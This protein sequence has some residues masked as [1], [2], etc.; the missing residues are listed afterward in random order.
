MPD[1]V[2]ERRG[3][4]TWLRLN[5]PERRNAYDVPLLAELTAAV[6]DAEAD[7]NVIVITGSGSAFCAGGFLGNLADPDPTEIRRMF[8]G[9]L[10][11]FD[12]IRTSLRPVIASVNGAAAG[13]G[14]E[15]VVACDLA[16]AAES[17]TFGQTGVRVGSAPV[18]GGTNLLAVSIGEKRAKEVAFLCQR[19]SARE[20]LDLGW[21]NRV[22]PDADLE[23]ATD[24]MVADL[25]A[26]SPRY[27]AVAKASSNV[28][29]NACRDSFLSGLAMLDQAIGSEDMLE[30]ARAF[31]EKRPPRFAQPG[32]GR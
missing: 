18:L 30:G 7:S 6:R 9:S 21:I 19:Y 22:V 29:W 25:S 27:L 23:T 28:W 31:L 2:V 1:I 11:L 3:T 12:A 16:I 15:L 13:G 17:A 24:A 32:D 8:R 10:T 26:M 20:A 14:N 4:A 5:R